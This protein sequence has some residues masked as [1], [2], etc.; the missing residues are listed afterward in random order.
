MSNFNLQLLGR[1]DIEWLRTLRNSCRDSFFNAG[2]ITPEQQETWFRRSPWGDERWVIWDRSVRVG[3]F[4]IQ[5]PNPELPIF[6]SDGRPV[7]YLSNLLVS[8]DYRGQGVIQEARHV[9]DTYTNVYVG[10]PQVTNAA[11]LR[12]CIKMGFVNRGA[13]DHPTYGQMFVLWKDQ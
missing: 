9:L 2:E 11:S 8:A 6:P 10:Y 12:S 1:D 4:S 3:Y 13:Y 7:R 5:A